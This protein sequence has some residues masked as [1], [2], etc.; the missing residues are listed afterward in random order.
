MQSLNLVTFLPSYA[1]GTSTRQVNLDRS[2]ARSH[3]A[4]VVHSRHGK[5]LKKTK[6]FKASQQHDHKK[7]DT[8]TLLPPSSTQLLSP[9]PTLYTSPS[10]ILRGSDEEG[11]WHEGRSLQFFI[12]KTA[13]EWFGWYDAEFW[14]ILTPQ[15]STAHPCLRHGLVAL[16]AYHEAV[17]VAVVDPQRSEKLKRYTVAQGQMAVSLLFQKHDTLPASIKLSMYIIIAAIS[18]FLQPSTFL[19]ALILQHNFKEQLDIMRTL[20]HSTIPQS[21][22]HFITRYLD[23]TLD[24]QRS[25]LTQTVD[26]QWTMR[27]AH[28]ADFGVDN[29]IHIPKTFSTLFHARMVLEQILKWTTYQIKTGTLSFDDS[30]SKGE[31]LIEMWMASLRKY[32]DSPQLAAKD[33]LTVKVLRISAKISMISIATI[34]EN[35]ELAFD[36]YTTEFRELA[37][38]FSEATTAGHETSQTNINFGIENSLMTLCA[39]P[40]MR[41]CRQPDI[42][43]DFIRAFRSTDRHEGMEAAWVWADIFELTQNIEE[44]GIQPPP[45]TCHDIPL[46]NRRRLISLSVFWKPYLIRLQYLRYPYEATDVEEYWISHPGWSTIFMSPPMTVDEDFLPNLVYGRGFMSMLRFEGL[47]DYHTI[48]NTK[49]YFNLPRV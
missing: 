21:D 28:S 27:A 33:M 46:E 18:S 38:V 8:G 1:P 14:R 30:I 6:R 10:L 17:G 23:P 34:N 40:A 36:K 39:S 25:K 7:A 37:D 24:R 20:P 35:D 44:Q 31:L 48:E 26:N 15:A 32:A 47:G 42:R 13:K 43:R 9:D 41:W 11:S 3:A 2:L 29:P 4:K 49:Y 5:S 22:W 19:Q 45:V 16:G 12:V